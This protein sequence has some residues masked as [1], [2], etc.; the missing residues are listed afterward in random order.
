VEEAVGEEGD[1]RHGVGD[2][3]HVVE[4]EGTLPRPVVRLVHVPQGRVPQRPVRPARPELHADLRSIQPA[5]ARRNQLG[6]PC[7]R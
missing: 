2:G 3:E 7:N 5:R 1:G 6:F 4:L